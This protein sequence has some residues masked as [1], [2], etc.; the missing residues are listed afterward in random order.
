MPRRLLRV[1]VLL[2]LLW[3]A[4]ATRGVPPGEAEYRR[5]P[6]LAQNGSFESDW[7]HN[8]VSAGTRFMLLEQS[9]WGY[10]QS[11]A[12]PDSWVI[13]GSARLDDTAGKFGTAC[14][15]ITSEATQVIYLCGETD[16][17]DGGNGYN[18]FRPL[19]ADLQ[20]HVR[21]RPLRFGVWCKT[22]EATAD[23]AMTVIVEYTSGE[24]ITPKTETISFKSGTHD[25]EYKEVQFAPAPNMGV[26]HAAVVK[27]IGG[28]GKVCFDGVLAGWTAPDD[29]P[30]LLTNGSFDQIDQDFPT[31]WSKPQ[32]WSWSRREYY[33]FTGWS[34]EQ[35]QMRGGAGSVM[36][37][38]GDNRALR[39]TVLPGDNLAVHGD[40]I[41]LNQ[42]E[43]RP[44]RVSAWVWADNLRWFELM[45]QDEMGQWLPQHDLA[46][47]MGTDEH[48]RNRLLAAGTHD[49]EY[50][51]KYF[52][53]REPVKKLTLWICAR[54]IDGRLMA[55][56][57]VGTAWVDDVELREAGS[58]EASLAQRQVAVPAQRPEPAERA[59]T[60]EVSFGE[61]L[62][63]RNVWR[64]QGGHPTDGKF[65][66]TPPSGETR[67]LQPAGEGA[68]A[69]D[70]RALCRDWQ[71]QYKLEGPLAPGFFGTPASIVS[72]RLTTSY[73]YP[74]ETPEVAVNLHVTR[75]SLKSEIGS[76][77]AVVKHPGGER[78]LLETKDV[79]AA[80]WSPDKPRPAMLIDGH[81]DARNLLSFSIDP[82]GLPV[83]PHDDPV[84]DCAVVVTLADTAGKIIA[85][86]ASES[87]GFIQRP[88]APA[89][90][91]TI[92][93][94]SISASGLMLV[95]GRPFF[96]RPFPIDKADLGG[97]S[98]MHHFPKTH[99]ILPLPFP[100]ELIFAPAE[101]QGWKQKVQAFVQQN[102]DDPKLFGY[103]FNHNGETTFWFDRWKEMADCQRK[104]AAWVREI[105]PD[106]LILS[107]HWLFGHGALNPETAAPF[108]FLDVIDVEPGLTW[109]PDCHAV[110]E[111]FDRPVAV[112]AGLETYY[113]QPPA[114]IRWRMY[115]ALRLGASDVGICPSAML[116]PRPETISFLRGL[117]GEMCGLEPTLAAAAPEDASTCDDPAVT[118]WERE[119][120]PIRYIVAMR[121][122]ES[123]A[124]RVRFTL[125]G[126]AAR[127][128]V[129]F[130]GREIAPS[131]T[132]FDDALAAPHDVHVYRVRK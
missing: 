101:E 46:G 44:L 73:A 119:N 132:T 128:E 123:G 81:A 49:W 40:P 106:H 33:R 62:W 115:E 16:P 116:Y 94:T 27:L 78:V 125:P 91:E 72:I 96:F 89:L 105:D 111:V 95:N 121:G 14:L 63:G 21:D 110:R 45:A 60:P 120:G 30:N 65:T 84:R 76:L 71:E 32:L 108:S 20:R 88:P 99:K 124:G 41:A 37:G 42:S 43:A 114:L 102:K 36:T 100:E 53:P 10:A 77:R 64:I 79:P 59:G 74:D 6:N 25:W 58:T 28:E 109:T 7:M 103:F 117:Y 18:A 70:V 75:E 83:H 129:L 85:E 113:S 11:D 112:V 38:R 23:P 13:R 61:R 2:I 1:A 118:I 34:H 9:D 5:L 66:L 22:E 50:V 19:P 90:P 55:K 24:N 56:N 80:L 52:A 35:G 15:R 8:K 86:T 107:A 131:G 98:R 39:L 47:F 82:S 12:I 29:A 54:G 48:Y 126:P 92:S 51:T 3:T 57:V 67:S 127:V 93:N 31:G 17:A 68:I 4:T 97:M 26:A 130:E 69:Y 122:K 87:F 104:V